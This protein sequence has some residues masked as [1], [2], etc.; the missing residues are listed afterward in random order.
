[1]EDI[2]LSKI[3]GKIKEFGCPKP[4]CGYESNSFMGICT[5]R[6]KT[7]ETF[8]DNKSLFTK[9][10]VIRCLWVRGNSREEIINETRFSRSN[11]NSALSNFN[12]Y[13]EKKELDS[14]E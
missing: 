9:S 5:H 13:R 11:V 8:K 12:E 10:N 1:M 6:A 4:S 2:E 14:G 7:H 3:L